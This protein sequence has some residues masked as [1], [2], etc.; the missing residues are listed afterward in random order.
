MKK[1]Y[2][3]NQSIIAGSFI[4]IVIVI[5]LIFVLMNKHYR[6]YFVLDTIVLSEDR[7]ELMIDDEKIKRLKDASFVYIDN[8]KKNID[9]KT[10]E[11][12]ILTKNEQ[13]YHHVTLEVALS[14][15][16]KE[17]DSMQIVVHDDKE[18]LFSLLIKSIKED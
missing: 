3:K 6:T 13:K 1:E 10:V 5:I 7:V 4:F 8:E 11:E 16:Y 12:N 15:Y 14:D 18:S 17:K 9:I 2:E